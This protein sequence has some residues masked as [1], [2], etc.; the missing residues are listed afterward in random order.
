MSRYSTNLLNILAEGNL[1]P[2]IALE[3]DGLGFLVVSDYVYTDFRY[4]D[5][6]LYGDPDAY[7][8]GLIPVPG[9]LRLI[10]LKDTTTSIN[11]NLDPDKARGASISSMKINMVDIDGEATKIASGV[12]GG[13]LLYRDVKVWVGYSATSSFNEDF[14]LV[15]RG[16]I[17]DIK[18]NQG[19]VDLNLSS[20]DQKRRQ[21]IA[22]QGDTEL[23]AGITSGSSVIPLKA[24]DNFIVAP[25]HPLY[26]GQDPD[27]KTYVL[28]DSEIIQYTGISSL[29][30]TGVTRGALGTTAA[31]HS[32]NSQATSYYVLDGVA[33]DLA[34]KIMLSDV[35][36]TPYI[37]DLA[38]A[39]VNNYSGGY[40]ANSFYFS[41]S[42]LQRNYNV[43]I[44]DYVKS[45]SFTSGSNNLSSWTQIL[46]VAFVNGGTLI[47]VDATLVDTTSVE[48]QVSFLSKWNSFGEFGLGLVPDEVDIEQHLYIGSTFLLTSDL[49]FYIRE[50]I[51]EGK[52]FIEAQLYRP[53][54]CY[55]LPSDKGGLARLSVGIHQP[56]LPIEQI[57]VL[58]KNNITNPDKLSIK[59]SVNKYHYNAV[60]H[61]FED[62]P[63]DDVLRRKKFTVAGTQVIPTGNKVLTIEAAGLRAGSSGD[64]IAQ[65]AGNKL[66]E[67]YRSAAEYIEG[68]D[69]SFS[70][71]A[72]V[73]IGDIIVLDP[74]DLNL[75]NRGAS[76]RF[77]DPTLMEVVNKKTDIKS[78]VISLSLIDTSFDITSRY[79]L[80][81]PASKI[82]SVISTTQFVIE[83]LRSYS[84]YEESEY[85]KWDNFDVVGVK[86]RDAS[87]TN[88]HETLISSI[89]GNTITIAVAPSF[90]LAAGMVMEYS[91]YNSASTQD[92]FKLVYGYVTDGTNDFGDGGKYYSMI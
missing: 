37:T 27:L 92:T 43:R 40:Q 55:S 16:V 64:V 66:L 1:E 17:D 44:G 82:K 49:Y 80:I 12:Y 23:S 63:L 45:N 4:G 46:D 32:I 29:N 75:I 65:N 31:S 11:Q 30:L 71:G 79:C 67:R 84:V 78:G 62:A 74:T 20:P 53:F 52:E 77:K 83:P 73:N 72:V 59:R 14:V 38:C 18:A 41:A 3:I 50:E 91:D 36:M 35:D 8:G 26:S 39:S 7:Y 81:G 57:Q 87:F 58:S 13:E 5:D 60:L 61:K 69:V 86:I 10:S 19:S 47:Q 21:V 48:G 68:I 89:S 54:A 2:R 22:P 28:I 51:S 90:S 24:V 70:V 33:M 88:V 34:L 85:K 6:V 56:P 25:T 15:F 42:D 9:Q 76:N